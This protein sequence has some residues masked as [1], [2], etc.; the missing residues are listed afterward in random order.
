MNDIALP[1]VTGGYSTV[2]ADPPWRFQNR[3]G[4]VAPE[5]KRLG[6]YETMTL[7][8]IKDLPVSEVTAKN[9]HL[10][11][12]VPNALLP[13]GLEVMEAW[14]FRYVTNIV[15]AKRRKDGGPDGRGVGFYFR[16]VT[17]LLLFGVKG[18]MR[19]LAPGRSQVN[20][21]ETRKREHS[22]KPDE[23]YAIIEACSPG[24]YLEMFA[25]YPQPHWDVWGNESAED[26][27]PQGKV[28]KGYEGGPII[29]KIEP[30]ERIPEDIEIEIGKALREEYEAGSSISD[31]ASRYDY[32][33]GRVR[34]L[35][36]KSG[37]TFRQR[38]P[39]KNAV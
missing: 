26:I 24:P 7:E 12:W 8:E 3:T 2:L 37:I 4:K 14:G 19:T 9:A 29:P 36:Q 18:R 30:N 23:Q 33:I 31:I 38:G 28:Y 21:I 17:E 20:M 13:Q 34:K 16:N 5:H 25:R 32:S 1:H 22:R 10:Y 39:R 6:R 15:W 27:V 11:L 35:L